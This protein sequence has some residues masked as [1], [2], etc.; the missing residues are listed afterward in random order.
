MEVTACQ[1]LHE[2]PRTRNSDGR[3]GPAQLP[4][5]DA[6]GFAAFFRCDFFG[7][8]FD[9][10]ASASRFGR[11]FFFGDEFFFDFRGDFFFRHEFFFG[12]RFDAAGFFF[13]HDFFGAAAGFGGFDGGVR[14]FAAVFE[15]VDG[16]LLLEF[17]DRGDCG[18]GGFF[19][20]G[21]VFLLGGGFDFVLGHRQAF[22]GAHEV[23]VA[24]DFARLA[25]ALEALDH[26]RI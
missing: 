4:R 25:E 20:Q 23:G 12:G 15:A 18:L 14:A 6:A 3:D 2:T 1:D 24:L 5:P 26:A 9:A 21:L 11:R 19:D 13:G 8:F 16:G 22:G 10:A 17:F 7:G